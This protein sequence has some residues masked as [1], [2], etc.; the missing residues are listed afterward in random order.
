MNG[1]KL[2]WRSVTFYL[3]AHLGT[4]L[5]AAVGA[6][7]LVGA[8]VVGDSVRGSLR[9]LA[10]Q[11]LGRVELAMATGERLFLDTLARRMQM[12]LS[13]LARAR[14]GLNPPP[15]A[16]DLP[17]VASARGG[18]ARANQARLIGV[19]PNFWQLAPGAPPLAALPANGVA[20][21]APLARQLGVG[22]GEE[23]LFRVA[24]PT[25]LSWDAPLTPD[26]D[27]T[28]AL[29]LKVAAVLDARQFGS[30]SLRAGQVAPFNA[31][32]RRSVL[33]EKVAAPGRA[34]LLLLG[35]LPPATNRT[36]VAALSAIQPGS[37]LQRARNILRQFWQ[38]ADA[39]LEWRELP[40]LR[41]LELRSPRVF[42]EPA[43]SDLLLHAGTNRL[44]AQ[45]RQRFPSLR[46]RGI[47]T[48]FVN[49]LRAGERSTP[50]SMV[51]AAGP[52]LVPAGLGD[53]EIVLTQWL[54]DDLQARVGDDIALRYYVIGLSRKLEERTNHFT[55]R[56]IIPMN[57]P[58]L[59]RTLMPDFP[60][61]T[62][63]ANCRDW[64]TGLPIDVSAIRDRDEAYWARY[65]GTPKAL[66]NLR[67]GQRLW[68]NRF[69]NL[70]AIRFA[71]N[72][73]RPL[74]PLRSAAQR[75]AIQRTL[76][77]QRSMLSMLLSRGVDPAALGLQLQ[78]VRQQ[79]LAAS[80]QGQ[81]FA[82]LFIGFSFFLITAALLLM[83]MLFQFAIEQRAGEVG[84]LLALGFTVRQVRRLLLG[85]GAA[86]ALL[87]T[88]LGLG[89]GV[90][91]ARAMVHGLS[92][93]W[94]EA[95]G[96]TPLSCHVQTETLVYG[97]LAAWGVAV[98]TL[99]LAL[100]K[101]A[102]RPA[103]ELM[104]E[105][106]I[107]PLPAERSGRGVSGWV[108]AGSGLGALGLVGAAFVTERGAAAGLFFGAGALL[109][110]AGLAGAAV[111][112]RRLGA[113]AATERLT[114]NALALRGLTRRRRRSVATLALLACGCFL[115]A[116]IGVFRLETPAD[117]TRRD[118]GTGGFLLVGS[119]TQPVLYDLNTPEGRDAYA[120]SDKLMAGVSVVSFR[121]RDGEDA[122]CL[123]LNRPQVPRVMGV[124]PEA[125]AHRGAFR[126][127]RLAAP[128]PADLGWNALDRKRCAAAGLELAPDEVPA[129]G[130]HESIQYAL[131][132][133][134]GASLPYTDSRGR[135]FKLRIVGA[136]A[137]SLL[138]GGLII[139]ADDFVRRFPDEA[140]YRWFLI[141]APPA[142]QEEVAA[143]L[144]RAL[145][146]LGFETTPTVARLA[147]FNAIQ[148][149][150]LGTFQIV[151]GLGLLLGSFGLGAVVL[152]NVLER[153][154]ELALMQAV[155]F[156]PRELQIL[157]LREHLA[158]LLGGL[159]IGVLAAA[160]A[161][162]P[163]I[164]RTGLPVPWGSLG[165]TLLA[166][167]ANG[168]LWTWLA[169]LAALKGNLL[170]A[171]RND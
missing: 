145:E 148:N 108:A 116:S 152:R 69:G 167:L 60:G 50:Y 18:Q 149:T 66:I 81:D 99:W 129:I 20:L 23:V 157:L 70:T 7:V 168:V 135:P 79:A 32:M 143:G 15:P 27:A 65:R 52:P 107:E 123:N 19:D 124:N 10:L 150:Y 74:P 132:T 75:A 128:L 30:F 111:I 6:A 91:Y 106:M 109:L 37:Y 73:S 71:P 63:A 144:T 122:S 84:T 158:L 162:L 97:A 102:A 38:P 147:R 121:V 118:S 163:T 125:L 161:V 36:L 137:H 104:N 13:A 9:D 4:L 2:V 166:V 48:Y 133:K 26:E 100:R 58:G 29:R 119:S 110:T 46:P 140:G 62:T 57:T 105:G 139:A 154:G 24:K 171:L 14:S 93:I 21:G 170:A 141:D 114:A 146:D 113:R 151:G 3:R 164:L 87:G 8:L 142:R 53:D 59:D 39:Q 94:R 47:L 51:T 96:G 72:V 49:E 56:A 28:V 138:Q 35:E 89:A 136:V 131:G 25:A 86:L 159:G 77:A 165:L 155:G 33:Q 5:G 31:F 88:L 67:A 78:P 41:A 92:T 153:R 134:V 45:I 156:T 169:T 160:A 61:M 68:S 64:D 120:L 83:A 82:S 54:A 17:A 12:G 76:A 130:D 90:G 40:D 103:R 95:I 34:N 117:A 126:F 101:Q 44:A 80:A 112:L 11:R 115:V 43:L 127:A 42:L 16:L 98:V 1:L 55:V 22:V 85:E